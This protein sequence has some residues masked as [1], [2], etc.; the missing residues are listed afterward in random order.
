MKFELAI[1]INLIGSFKAMHAAHVAAPA[2]IARAAQAQHSSSARMEALAAFIAGCLFNRY[3]AGAGVGLKS[4][5]G[6]VEI[7]F[8]FSTVKFGFSL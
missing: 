6:A 7:A 3:F 5:F 4:T 1:N 8:S 2:T